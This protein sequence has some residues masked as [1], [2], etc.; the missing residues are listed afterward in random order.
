VLDHVTLRVADY[1]RSRAFYDGA[2]GPLG[3]ELGWADEEGRIAEWGDLSIAQ[4]DRPMTRNAHVALRAR[5]PESVERFHAAAIAGGGR[6]NGAPGP[7]PQYGPDYF[8]AYVLDLDGTNVEAVVR[9]DGP[10]IDHVSLRVRSLDASF[11]FYAGVAPAIGWAAGHAGEGY[12]SFHGASASVWLIQDGRPTEHLHL[13]FA[14]DDRATV[15]R[16][17]AA[18]LASGGRDNGGPG[19]RPHYHSGYYGAFALDPD[20]NNVEAVFHGR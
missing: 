6:D 14:A 16:F 18:A 19:E 13:A 10:P 4:D 20:G 15:D 1:R 12:A 3:L 9:D 2:L 17:H 8:A 5:S 7:R 11:G